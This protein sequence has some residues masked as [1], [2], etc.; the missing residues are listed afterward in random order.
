MKPFLT[1][2]FS[3]CVALAIAGSA[4]GADKTWYGPCNDLWSNAPNW[5]NSAGCTGGSVPG[6]NDDVDI[7][8]S[9][10]SGTLTI[11]DVAAFGSLTLTTVDVDADGTSGME[12]EIST[13]ATQQLNVTTISFVGNTDAREAFLDFNENKMSASNTDAK[14][15]V[16]FEVDTSKTF[17]AGA[18]TV[19]AAAQ[20]SRLEKVES[21]SLVATSTSIEAGN[22]AAYDAHLKVTLGNFAPGDLVIW[23]HNPD[24]AGNPLGEALLDFDAGTMTDPDSMKMRGFSRIDTE[25]NI[26][27]TGAF[28]VEIAGVD[29]FKTEA[30]LDI[31]SDKFIAVDSLVVAG[32]A[33]NSAKLT[34]VGPG[35]LKTN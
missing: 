27:V 25:R 21:G 34:V 14:S 24:S 28:R 22:N 10:D 11:Y 17:S 16:T 8:A 1:A 31:A 12:L 26:T 32:D 30:T 6:A 4:T 35:E 29:D 13:S 7:F 19:D 5:V 3:L 15:Y 33:S 2:I 20:F 23:G 18:L 9:N